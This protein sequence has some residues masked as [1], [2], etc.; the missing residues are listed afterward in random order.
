MKN[1][2]TTFYLIRHGET[3]WNKNGTTQGHT[4]T[5]LNAMGEEQAKAVAKKFKNIKFD[6]AFSSDLLRA[7][8]TTEII[9]LEHKLA[10]QTTNLLREK[11]FGSLTGKPYQLV[12]T[13]TKLILE[14]NKNEQSKYKV[15]PDAENDEEVA[16]RIFTFLRETALA[17][18][19]K[20]ILVG[21]HGGV[22]R[23]I[24]IH[25]AIKS[26]KDYEHMRMKNGGY[27]KLLS[28]GVEFL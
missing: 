25:L 8:R 22:L 9:A 17:Y 15:V 27:I 18:P 24:L 12:M 4:D 6:L 7:K 19:G 28:D 16:S 10:V 2:L 13:H 20:N 5:A 1:N 3:D 11:N 14:L 23:V 21:T 26:Y